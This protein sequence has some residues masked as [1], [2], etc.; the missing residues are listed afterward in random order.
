M[1]SSKSRKL[2]A[3]AQKELLTVLK[4]RFE[5]ND[6]RHP[7]VKWETI[8]SK[9]E[10][11]PEKL[12]TIHEMEQL[13]GEPDVVV[14]DAKE[15]NYY[16]VDCVKESPKE[17]RSCCYD[18][19]ALESRKENK[20]KHS[21]VGVANAI[22]VDLLTEAQYRKLQEIESFDLKTSSWVKTPEAIRKL[23]GAIFCDR[24]FNTVFVYH[25]GVESYYGSR[26]FRGIV[27]I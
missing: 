13:G 22:G 25:N 1:A 12:W 14:L 18:E 21:A 4:N 10:S 6:K 7:G 17:R 26:G 27:M 16:F 2:T 20:P 23:G 8:L 5:Q 15:K 9:L 3:A 19:A 11:N 24:R